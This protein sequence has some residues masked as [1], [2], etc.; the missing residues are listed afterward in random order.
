MGQRE[1][2]MKKAAAIGKYAIHH[3][4]SGFT[5]NHFVSGDKSDDSVRILLDELYQLGVDNEWMTIE[6]G[7][8]N[9]GIGLLP[10]ISAAGI[11]A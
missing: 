4:R 9:H 3:F 1:I 8:F 10:S 7:E 5:D 2:R 6:P 11:K